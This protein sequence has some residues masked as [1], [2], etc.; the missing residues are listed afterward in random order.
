MPAVALV[1]AIVGLSTSTGLAVLLSEQQGRAEERLM[2]QRA[3]AM[4]AAVTTEARRYVETLTTLAAGAASM[5]E[6]DA[7]SFDALTATLQGM[8][9]PG[10]SGIAFVVPADG[11]E[12]PAVQ[13]QWRRRG[14]ADL[15]LRPSPDR[16]EHIF[17]VL[18]RPVSAGTLAPLGQDLLVSP[19]ATAALLRGRELSTVTVSRPY[20]LLS[21]RDLPADERQL[22]FLISAP[23]LAPA[24]DGGPRAFRG[25]LVMGMR[26][27]DFMGSTLHQTG[28]GL[29]RAALLAD[30]GDGWTTVA[31]D[32]PDPG[33]AGDLRRTERIVI[34]DQQWLLQAHA[35]R[36]DLPGGDDVLA[37]AV[38]AGG[39]GLT[40]L[41]TALVLVLA[42]AHRR[43]ERRVEEA[44]RE[45]RSARE[46]AQ[47]QAGLLGAV[48]DSLGD[49]VTVVDQ[50]GSYLLSNRAARSILR[51]E[52]PDGPDRWPSHHGVFLAD[53]GEPFPVADLPVV[54][55]LAGESVD[56][57]EMFLRN[58][59]RPDG[60]W[61][62][63]SARP[64]DPRTGQSGAVTVFQDVTARR[65][66]HE[67]VRRSEEQLRLLLDGARDHA[68]VMLDA[69]GHV[70]SWSA[71]AERINGYTEAE[72]LGR[73]YTMLFPADAVAAGEPQ[74]ALADAVRTGRIEPEWSLV[75]KDGTRFWALSVLTPVHD[76]AG[77]LRGFVNVTRDITA[78]KRD[79][80]RF[81]DLLE[82]AP[83]ALVGCTE[84]GT[85]V[86]A[87][88][89]VDELFGY[90]REELLGSPLEVLVPEAAASGH[91]AHR[92]RYL[93]DPVARPMGSGM[94][95]SARRRDGS[96]FPAEVS[97]S[98]LE[99]DDGVIVSAAVRDI[100]DR[101]RA[102]GELQRLNGALRDLNTELELR[103]HERTAQLEAQAD[104]LLEVNSELEAFSYSVSHDLRAPLRAVDGFAAVL[105]M[106]HADQLDDAGR[107][108]LDRVRAGAQQ[109]GELIDGL[110]S[111]S[112]LQ[113][114]DM[115]VRPVDLDPLVTDVWEELAVERAGRVVDLAV[116]HLPPVEGDPRLLRHVVANLV[117][118][119]VKYTR[120]RERALV[121]VG[122]RTGDDGAPVYF[123]RDNGTG[124]DMRYADKLFK[125][126]QRLHR[127]EDYEGTGIGLALTARI[128]HRH[129]GR[130][131][132]D[133]EPDR[134]ATFSFTLPGPDAATAL[135]AA[136]VPATSADPTPAIPTPRSVR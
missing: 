44:T 132:A 51:L 42:T 15:Q 75:R 96:L 90:R 115:S 6:V 63:V 14:V 129:G 99:S 95:L 112:R 3:T 26:G 93:H 43:A 40:V 81:R 103:V 74:R 4:Q 25:W 61:L 57:V 2:D 136:T 54:R 38:G 88:S 32:D 66:A 105:A 48:M 123:V 39:V 79:E 118:N 49:G 76:D 60:L 7:A 65:S 78:R 127:A 126:F 101:V 100:S 134:G 72:V 117:G 80:A 106:D 86:F 16:D 47:R 109:M 36:A 121:E 28:E 46:E 31:G 17:S 19:Q 30:G 87:N 107:R 35:H 52:E 108:Y 83:D 116:G 33:S 56:D 8:E 24:A 55:A 5:P 58:E 111:F 135:V 71:N 67:A 85:I 92:A 18:Q 73:P 59:A 37:L 64:L 119:A 84:D 130:I 114:Q 13:E 29:A 1:V 20:Q 102:Q 34:A 104:A 98:T 122:S 12:V 110:L 45:L 62:E 125:V 22:S 89:K 41:S 11:A 70:A 53:G 82:A 50:D 10:A 68:I 128:L 133:A 94:Q 77:A 131:W 69:Q 21:D 113:R 91:A 120:G 124:F 27:E 23:V 97:L 9:L